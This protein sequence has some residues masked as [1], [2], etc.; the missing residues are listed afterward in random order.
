LYIKNAKYSDFG[1][2]TE[3]KERIVF[4]DKVILKWILKKELEGVDCIYLV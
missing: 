3:V 4:V 1:G 2:K